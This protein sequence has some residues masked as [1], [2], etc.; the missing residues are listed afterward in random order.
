MIYWLLGLIIFEILILAIGFPMQAK[1]LRHLRHHHRPVWEA[2]NRRA[3]RR[4]RDFKSMPATG[5]LIS[6]FLGDPEY[7]QNETR[8]YLWKARLIVLINI[9]HVVALGGI[10]L[11]GVGLLVI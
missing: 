4:W 6:T 7:R 2:M 1:Y 5:M 8:S 10:A 9:L 11:L 3:S